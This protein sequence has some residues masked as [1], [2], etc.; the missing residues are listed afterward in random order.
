MGFVSLRLD[1]DDLPSSTTTAS[2]TASEAP[3]SRPPQQH[4]DVDVGDAAKKD[5]AVGFGYGEKVGG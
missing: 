3:A 2:V 1:D 5:S 4:H